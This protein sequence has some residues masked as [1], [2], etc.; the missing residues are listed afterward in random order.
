VEEAGEPVIMP[1]DDD[2]F[3]AFVRL[4]YAALVRY[5]A[6]LLG[7]PAG[8]EDLVQLS[9]VKL[10]RAFDRVDPERR[11]AYTRR[12]MARA[13]WRQARRRWNGEVPTAHVPERAGLGDGEVVVDDRDALRRA[14]AGLP[15]RQRVVLTLRYLD[16]L[17]E[18][19]TADVLGCSV[20]TVKSRAARGIEALRRSGLASEH[21]VT[22]RIGQQGVEP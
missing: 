5:G 18:A 20:G 1:L 17:S 19:E 14:L 7:D 8:A 22:P 9:L 21:E 15:L 3:S 10:N 13:G 4:R 16:E 2:E 12:V 6:S 11:E